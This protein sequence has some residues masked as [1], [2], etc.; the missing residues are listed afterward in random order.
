MNGAYLDIEESELVEE[1]VGS[2]ARPRSLR[3]ARWD[4]VLFCGLIGVLLI[5]LWSFHYFPSE[6]GPAHG[7]AAVVARDYDRP[8][9][10]TFREFF[11][12]S[13]RLVPNWIS[14]RLLPILAEIF[15]VEIAEKIVLSLY[16]ILL[17]LSV[18]YA[19]GAIRRRA[20]G[21]AFCIFPLVPGFYYHEGLLDY[22][23]G[24]PVFFFIVGYWLKHRRRM[25]ARQVMVLAALLL[26]GFLCHL[27]PTGMAGLFI[28]V[29]AFTMG[30]GGLGARVGRLVPV[31]AAGAPVLL[32]TVGF[33]VGQ[34]SVPAVIG[35]PYASRLSRLKDLVR[36]QKA[37]ASPEAALAA[38]NLALFAG[39]TGWLLWRRGARKFFTGGNAFLL[40]AALSAGLFL[41]APDEG[42]G[43]SM[44]VVRLAMYPL[45]ALI[46]WWAAQPI[47]S[48]A[49]ARLRL[50]CTIVP[51]ALTLLLIASM[52]VSYGRVTPYLRDME[53]V[54][55][56]IPPNSTL[57]L[58][59]YPPNITLGPDGRLLIRG[60]NIFMHSGSRQAG[61]RGIAILNSMVAE[62]N[63]NEIRYRPEINPGY[64]IVFDFTGY[65]ARIGKP[66]EYVILWTGGTTPQNADAR[67]IAKQLH[68]DYD[69]I[70]HLPANRLR[71]TLS[72]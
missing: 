38:V 30:G 43:G 25:E 26:V 55:E 61:E 35:Y 51:V 54:V 19:L 62:T 27:V 13:D 5:P 42:V 29:L 11:V 14:P 57:W 33:A 64:H 17:P 58:T 28:A 39:L 41:F 22:C 50:A 10:P 12:K 4:T 8:D 31:I 66:L 20:A 71:Q 46:L 36:I 37:F 24:L 52:I 53:A 60:P 7:Y 16:L 15:P 2:R 34:H 45:L 32:L 65:A 23:I 9:R 44:L 56:Q 67:Q 49:F 63:Y 6:D 69:L 18:R 3:Y 68:E 1:W 72:P 48:K 70:L 47:G 21:L 40:V 59:S